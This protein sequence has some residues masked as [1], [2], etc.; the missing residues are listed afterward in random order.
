M[1]TK[2]ELQYFENKSNTMDYP[3]PVGMAKVELTT[4]ELSGSR[5]TNIEESSR[6]DEKLGLRVC[7]I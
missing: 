1:N 5:I 6:V 3:N 4:W 7:D 2:K